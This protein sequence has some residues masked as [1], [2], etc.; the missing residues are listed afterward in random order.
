SFVAASLNK[1]PINLKIRLNNNI[2]NLKIIEPRLYKII[3]LKG[4]EEKT[5]NLETKLK[6]K[7]YSFAFE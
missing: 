3:E 5:L 1:K 6:I 7:I 2:K 4:D